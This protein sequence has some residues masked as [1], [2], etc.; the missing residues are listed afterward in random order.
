MP[1]NRNEYNREW[2]KK[3]KEHRLEMFKIYGKRWRDKNKE[4]LSEKAKK[5]YVLDRERIMSVKK[6]YSMTDKGKEAHREESMR[7]YNKPENRIKRYAQKTL[8]NAV[9]FGKIKKLACSVC[10]NIKS[11]GHHK[12]YS[13][14][15][16]VIWLCSQHHKDVHKEIENGHELSATTR[17]A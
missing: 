7:Y 11:H 9:K 3:N 8:N 5:R 10:G 15:L 13:R 12:D 14:P 6:D 17:Q 1:K 4:S 2:Y 16:E